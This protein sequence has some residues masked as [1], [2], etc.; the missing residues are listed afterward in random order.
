MIN[1]N[2]LRIGNWVQAPLG[3]Y[4]QVE[5]LGHDKNPNYIFARGNGEFGQNGFDGIPLTP[6]ILQACGF[7]HRGSIYWDIEISDINFQVKLYND[8]GYRLTMKRQMVNSIN[9]LGIYKRLHTL[10]NIIH[11]LTGTELEVKL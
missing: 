11:A 4:M 2:E 7:K 5:I 8:G 10:Q 1:A 3:E 6:E 9:V